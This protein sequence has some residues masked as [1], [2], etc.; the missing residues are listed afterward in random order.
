MQE[1]DVFTYRLIKRQTRA[2]KYVQLLCSYKSNLKRVHT[3]IRMGRGLVMFLRG[4]EKISE[5]RCHVFTG[6]WC[7]QSKASY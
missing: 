6:D 3:Y 2:R 7:R 1:D 4:E 5:T